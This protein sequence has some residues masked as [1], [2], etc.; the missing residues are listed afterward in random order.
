[1]AG[2]WKEDVLADEAKPEQIHHENQHSARCLPT[3]LA[4]R[5]HMNFDSLLLF[6]STRSEFK[7]RVKLRIADI[8]GTIQLYIDPIFGGILQLVEFRCRIEFRQKC[9]AIVLRTPRYVP[10]P[11]PPVSSPISWFFASTPTI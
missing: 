1:M 2:S 11:R 7:H 5:R 10:Y 8:L 6:I 9:W 3:P 4:L